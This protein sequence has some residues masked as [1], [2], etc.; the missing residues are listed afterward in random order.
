MRLLAMIL[1]FFILPDR[2]LADEGHHLSK[3][4]PHRILWQES[5]N[6]A[7]V[8]VVVHE[9]GHVL[10]QPFQVELRVQCAGTE[11][12]LHEQP[13]QD[14]FSA[15]DLDPSSL[16][17]NRQ[18][19]ALAMKAKA[20]DLNHYYDQIAAG[21]QEPELRCQPQTQISKLSLNRLCQP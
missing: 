12:P 9:G 14:S 18:K 19:T 1:F 4:S 6:G 11:A 21:K 8:T 15:C 17:V 10:G 20:A 3:A 2:V 7:L 13:V 16:K 5:V